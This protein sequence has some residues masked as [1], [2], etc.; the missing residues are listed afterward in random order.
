MSAVVELGSTCRLTIKP[1][2]T[3]PIAISAD[4]TG[5]VASG[6]ALHAARA[7]GAQAQQFVD[8]RDRQRARIEV[9]LAAFAAQFAQVLLVDRR[10]DPFG[11]QAQ[12]KAA[13]QRDDATDDRGV[14]RVGAQPV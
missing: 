5:S 9:P 8:L 1:M 10:L 3:M 13:R 2:L 11:G 12:V 4:G 14:L 7:Q 6:R